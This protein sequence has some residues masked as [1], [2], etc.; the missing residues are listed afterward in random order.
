ALWLGEALQPGNPF[1]TT[2]RGEK[3]GLW[4]LGPHVVSL[5][6][7]SLGPVTAV[8]ADAGWADITHLVLHHEGGATS[9][10]TVT[11]S[12]PAGVDH[13]ELPLGGEPG[14]SAAPMEEY[15][16]AALQTALAELAANARSGRTDHPCDVRFGREVV[17]VLAD[18]E[19]Q[20]A[21]RRGA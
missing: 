5:L 7:A 3:G 4:D 18:A 19:R 1:N 11:L 2:W 8:T 6:W 13:V 20:V 21:A 17:R 16:V 15:P 14:L 10:A 12:A 9:N